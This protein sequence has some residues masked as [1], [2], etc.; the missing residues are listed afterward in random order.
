MKILPIFILLVAFNSIA[1]AQNCLE[2]AKMVA[3]VISENVRKIY[4]DKLA[5]A[6]EDYQ[7]NPNNADA[8]IWLGRRTAYLGNYKESIKIFTEGIEKFPKDARF[9]RHRG[10]R[11]ITNRCFD[12]AIR[13][14]ESAAKLIRGKKDEIEPDG[15]PNARNTPTSTLQSNIFYH[16]GFAFYVKGDFQNALKAYQNCEKVSKNPDMLVATKHWLYMTLRRLGKK[17]EAEKSIADIKDNLE[18]IEND[19][20]YKL[21]K[22]YQ[23]KLKAED[24][25]TNDAN[26]L[27]NASL[28]YGVGNWFLYNGESEKAEK[29]FRQI[30]NGNQWASFGFIA[31]EAE[32]KMSESAKFWTQLE[33]LCGKAFGGTVENAPADDTTFKGK[34]LVMHVRSC[35]KNRIRI[36][37]FVGEDKS[38]TWVLTRQ[39]DRIL[40][41]HDHRHEDGKPDAVTMYGGLTTN[42]GSATRQMFPADQE[43]V[44]V[45]AAAAANVW[46]IDLMPN[47]S[48]SYNLRRVGTE[49][50]FSIKFD[51]KKEIPAPS[52]PW[53]W[54][55]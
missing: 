35:E 5:E 23:G 27:G 28:G 14:F 29:I 17:T 21:V 39:N 1:L 16:L 11:F 31:A 8:I 22:L 30:T 18:I 15:L 53:G 3:P 37:F 7:K 42:E 38:R 51:L 45:I 55:D 52:A 25:M 13:D 19:D 2:T 26:S 54:K 9:Y 24:L 40:L 43:T 47:E 6:T 20:Y 12:D 41:K 49:R 48:F 44:R 10:H 32:Q 36:P 4:L 33:K 46:W 50:F 34:T